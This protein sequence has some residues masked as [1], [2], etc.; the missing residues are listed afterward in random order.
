MVG[1]IS[2]AAEVSIHNKGAATVL[3][4]SIQL[5]NLESRTN[6]NLL[7]NTCGTSLTPN[8]ICKLTFDFTPQSAGLHTALLNLNLKAKHAVQIP[9]SGHGTD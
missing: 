5:S 9:I 1:T 3:L 7:G 8:T 2:T 4:N 6:F